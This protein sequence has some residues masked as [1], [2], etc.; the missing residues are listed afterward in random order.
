MDAIKMEPEVD[1]LAIHWS[2]NTDTDEKKP[3][4][5]KGKSMVFSMPGV[6]DNC[7]AYN[8]DRS[9]EVKFE[10]TGVPPN[11]AMVKC[12]TKEENLLDP[13]MA[14]TKTECMDHSYDFTS[15][16]NV[17][18]SVMPINFVTTECKS[19]GGTNNDDIVSPLKPC[20]H[21]RCFPIK[22]VFSIFCIF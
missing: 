17:E 20:R 18:E 2:D 16:T 5:E 1:P 3:L 13:H 19:E 8:Y 4:A 22:P 12:E 10:E 14:G 6:Q 15:E 21:V 9:S 11:F 7:V